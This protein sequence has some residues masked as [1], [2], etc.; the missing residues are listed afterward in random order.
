MENK[1]K[2]YELIQA[3]IARM[4]SASMSYKG[5]MVVTVSAI[6]GAYATLDKP[7]VIWVALFPTLIFWF[8]DA[9]HLSVE[10][11]FRDLYDEAILSDV[12]TFNMTP[13]P[14]SLWGSILAMF[15]KTLLPLYGS[16]LLMVIGFGV[17][18]LCS[19]P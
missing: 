10:K 6:L 13:A 18:H 7:V 4:S 17:Y 19:C 15:S 14:T 5:W 8:L 16:V 9:F 12:V 1:L 2:Y 3:N 11:K